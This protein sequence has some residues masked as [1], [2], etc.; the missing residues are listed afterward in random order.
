MVVVYS[1]RFSGSET[2]LPMLMEHIFISQYEFYWKRH[3]L[4]N[5]LRKENFLDKNLRRIMSFCTR[6]SDGWPPISPVISKHA[7]FGVQS[8]WAAAYLADPMPSVHWRAVSLTKCRFNLPSPKLPSSGLME[9]YVSQ[10]VCVC[11]Y[12]LCKIVHYTCNVEYTTRGLPCLQT[13]PDLC[14]AIKTR[15]TACT[16]HT[17]P[18]LCRACWQG[19]LPP[20]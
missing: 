4:K 6:R 1:S 7:I 18:P 16:V 11:L 12:G 15:L 14:W 17:T 19:S 13:R 20:L 8:A 2:S 10:M 9:F 5:A 3:D